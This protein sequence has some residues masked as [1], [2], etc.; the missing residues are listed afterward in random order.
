[1]I[2]IMDQNKDIAKLGDEAL[3]RATGGTPT[4]CDPPVIATFYE[5]KN[6]EC[7]KA[8]YSNVRPECCPE[9][10]SQDFQKLKRRNL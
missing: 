3:D 4:V 2:A 9:C 1:M 6:P 8:F 7:Q 10:G 5:C